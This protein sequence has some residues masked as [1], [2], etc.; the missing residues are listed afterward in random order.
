MASHLD[1][2]LLLPPDVPG[3]GDWGD[4]GT[5]VRL[6]LLMEEGWW[7]QGRDPMFPALNPPGGSTSFCGALSPCPQPPWTKRARIH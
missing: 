6:A 2:F 1:S 3:R 4:G 5:V 7:N